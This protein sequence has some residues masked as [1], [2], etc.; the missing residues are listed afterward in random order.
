MEATLEMIRHSAAAPRELRD[1][2]R[3]YAAQRHVVERG[4]QV[5]MQVRLRFLRGTLAAHEPRQAFAR[6][7]SR[8]P[9]NR[10]AQPQA[11]ATPTVFAEQSGAAEERREGARQLLARAWVREAHTVMR[12]RE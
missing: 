8:T 2:A 3:E 12:I 7:A 4:R 6:S 9:E 10:A 5:Q 11:D 1:A